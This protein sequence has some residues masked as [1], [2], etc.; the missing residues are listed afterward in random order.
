MTDR[1][2]LH[3][4]IETDIPVILIH[5]GTET[6]G[7]CL[8]IGLGGMFVQTDTTFDYGTTLTVRFTLPGLDQE[9]EAEVTARWTTHEGLGLRFGSLRA[10]E[11]WAINQLFK[12]D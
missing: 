3:D 12:S 1:R 9:V 8:N 6:P 11:V 4:R 10:R 5:E 2:R 7:V